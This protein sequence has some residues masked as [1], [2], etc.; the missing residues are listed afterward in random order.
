MKQNNILA[1]WSQMLHGLTPDGVVL[2]TTRIGRLFGYGFL[3][4]MDVPT[5]QS[6]T[7][8]VVAPDERS[9]AAGITGIAR[10]TGAS[11]SPVVNGP[12]LTNTTLLSVPFFQVALRSY[13]T[14]CSTAVLIQ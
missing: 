9:A 12:L 4:Q 3:S 13:M 8:A 2:F 7:M 1:K 11:L 10:T 14:Y 6:Y 5:R